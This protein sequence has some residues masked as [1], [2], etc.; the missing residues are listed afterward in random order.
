[1]NT[2]LLV[3]E[4]F[5]S[6]DGEGKTAGMLTTFIRLAGC[7]LRCKWCD[8][9]YA[10]LPAQGTP[11]SV[12]DAAAAVTTRAVTLTGGE[13]LVQPAALSLVALLMER[14]IDVNVETNGS[15]DI[16]PLFALPHAEEHLLVTLDWKLPASGMEGRM[17]PAAFRALRRGDVLKF[18]VSDPADLARA[19]AVLAEIRPASL[20]YLSPVFGSIEPETLVDTLKQWHA[21]GMDVSRVR[22]QLQLH[23]IIWNPEQRG[24]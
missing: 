12:E 14:G 10:L 5:V 11:M 20:I 21:D 24:V 3:N 16:A 19:R 4:I 8:T 6:I 23:K 13:P 7:N 9:A 22:V 1:M 15:C 2:Q 18:V 17:N